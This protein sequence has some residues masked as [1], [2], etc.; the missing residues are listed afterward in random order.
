M[1]LAMLSLTSCTGCH[2][3]LFHLGQDLMDILKGVEVTY[4][5]V[6][7]DF[8]KFSP[9]D[10]VL[11]EGAVRNRKDVDSLRKAREHS[12]T[13]VALGTCSSYGGVAGLGNSMPC[14]E[15]YETAYKD[16]AHRYPPLMPRLLPLDSYVEVDYYVTGCPPPPQVLSHFFSDL[17][18]GSKHRVYDL[19]VCADCPR[20]VKGEFSKKLRHV[21]ERLPEEEVCLLQQGYICLGSVTRAGCGALCPTAGYPCDGCRGPTHKILLNPSHGIYIDLVRRRSHYLDIS[22]DQASRDIDEFIDRGLYKYTLGSPFLRRRNMERISSLLH[23]VN[24]DTEEKELCD[25]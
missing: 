13:L 3:A 4:S 2:V 10:V 14:I 24:V 6:L 22:E 8:K 16:G 11:V 12:G 23:R 25:A 18:G 1:K 20:K 17:L 19:P 5:T 9:C 21:H 15:I 7:A